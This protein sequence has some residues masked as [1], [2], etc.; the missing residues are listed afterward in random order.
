MQRLFP[1]L[2]PSALD[3]IMRV[4]VQSLRNLGKGGGLGNGDTE[5]ASG[6]VADP[7]QPT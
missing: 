5:A 6:P 2:G 7:P 4:S 3:V 1:Y